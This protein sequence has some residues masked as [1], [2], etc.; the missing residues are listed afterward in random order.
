MHI[1]W[2]RTVPATHSHAV[3]FHCSFSPHD[4]VVVEVDGSVVVLEPD[5]SVVV[6]ELDGSVV[7]LELDGAVLELDGAVL[8]LDGAVLEPDGEVDVDGAEEPEG[9]PG[10]PDLCGPP[11]WPGA[12]CAV[13]QVSACTNVGADHPT[14]TSNAAPMVASRN[15]TLAMFLV[16]ELIGHPSCMVSRL[17][18]SLPSSQ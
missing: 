4:G 16:P 10:C 1:P 5:G 15:P 13:R 17:R 18:G 14:N 6:L 9:F 7:V 11:G 2:Y 12:G 3:P 8:E